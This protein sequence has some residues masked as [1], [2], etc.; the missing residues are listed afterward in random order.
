MKKFFYNSDSSN[1]K[2]NTTTVIN[3]HDEKTVSNKADVDDS[4]LLI[5]KKKQKKL[6]KRKLFENAFFLSE[7]V[8]SNENQKTLL[9]DEIEKELID[10]KNEEIPYLEKQNNF[11]K[12]YKNIAKKMPY[13][14]V[15]TQE[16]ETEANNK[17]CKSLSSIETSDHD[18]ILPKNNKKEIELLKN[19][20]KLFLLFQKEN[21]N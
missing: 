19:K 20:E 13:D 11:F 2:N 21:S 15:F 6:S 5:S 16:I 7:F 14:I 1:F 17:I 4:N 9:E 10:E 3:S 18:K 8:F 12:E